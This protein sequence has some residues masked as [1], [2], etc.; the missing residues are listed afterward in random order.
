M[1]VS[2]L[3]IILLFLAIV[4]PVV[5][6]LTRKHWRIHCVLGGIVLGALVAWGGI[7]VLNK[8]KN[9]HV[10]LINSINA[11]TQRVDRVILELQKRELE[12]G[13]ENQ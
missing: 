6:Y 7:V 3:S 1:A 12:E 5:I 13:K 4:L 10:E 11:L 9:R 2:L 8:E